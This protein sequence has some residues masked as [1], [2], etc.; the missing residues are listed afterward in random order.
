MEIQTVWNN[1]TRRPRFAL[2]E[3]ICETTDFDYLRLSIGLEYEKCS[4]HEASGPA[5]HAVPGT[6]IHLTYH[7]S[8]AKQKNT[9]EYQ[10]NKTGFLIESEGFG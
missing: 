8:L 6:S 10:E 9:A 1:K 4:S 2:G 7:F 3:I 5:G